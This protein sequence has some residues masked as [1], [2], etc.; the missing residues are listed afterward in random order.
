M[1]IEKTEQQPNTQQ[2]ANMAPPAPPAAAAA[3]PKAESFAPIEG[4]KRKK[5]RG[6][7]VF[8]LLN[9]GGF[10]LVGNEITALGIAEITEKPGSLF[11]KQYEAFVNSFRVLK[12]KNVPAYLSEGRMPMVLFACIAG[13]FMVPPIKHFEDRKGKMVRELDQKLHSKAE[14]ESPE[15]VAAHEEMDNAPKQ[16]WAS[17]WKGRIVTVLSA[18]TVDALAGWKNSVL[19]KLV[20]APIIENGVATPIAGASKWARFASLDHIAFETAQWWVKAFKVPEAKRVVTF[21]RVEKLAWLLTLSTTLTALFYGTSK[22]FAKNQAEHKEQ[23]QEQVAHAQQAPQDPSKTLVLDQ[24]PADP[25]EIPASSITKIAQHEALVAASHAA[26][27]L[28]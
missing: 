8:D 15:I 18:I 22:L 2:Q 16:T 6:E 5:T 17:L 26:P 10:G 4:I 28:G 20:K 14:N 27:Q 11:N 1:T 9:Y 13:M 23:R 24:L 3:A 25:K 12:G 21:G 7:R 19:P